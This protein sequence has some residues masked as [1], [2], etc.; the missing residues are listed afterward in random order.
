MAILIY[1]GGNTAAKM[2]ENGAYFTRKETEGLVPHNDTVTFITDDISMLSCSEGWQW[3]LPVN[4]PAM[5]RWRAVARLD[6]PA[7][8]LYGQVLFFNNKE[9]DC[10]KEEHKMKQI[11][12]YTD[13][14]C[15]KN[16]GGCGGTGWVILVNG[17]IV[18]YG[19]TGYVS[20]TN[21]RM[22]MRA[23]KEA[24]DNLEMLGIRQ[25]IGD[26]ITVY[27]DSE[28][29]VNPLLGVWK[30]HRNLDLWRFLFAIHNKYRVTWKWVRG[31]SG[32]KYNERCD[33]LANEARIHDEPHED[34]GYMPGVRTV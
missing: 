34:V 21:N 28:N 16:P 15:L 12:I 22:E 14:S 13:G 3:Q 8:V 19:G 30:A 27:T 23:V 17:E 6:G 18:K 33:E 32:N 9:F 25:G 7:G 20:T 11:E 5:E 1:P 2:P 10:G 4:F 26:T 24:F 31:H 29:V